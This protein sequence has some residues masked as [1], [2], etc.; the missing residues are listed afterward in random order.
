MTDIRLFDSPE[1]LAAGAALFFA[2]IAEESLRKRGRF[3]VALA[4]GSTPEQA[5]GLLAEPP[6]RDRIDWTRTEVFFGDERAV[7]PDH[8]ESNYCMASRTLLSKVPLPDANIHRIEAERTD[9]EQAARDYERIL[10][11]TLGATK[12][13]PP[14]LDLILLGIGRDGHTASIF[15]GSEELARGPELVAHML[16]TKTR[17]ARL[18]LTFPVLNA[19]RNV[20]FL[21]SGPAKAEI[22]SAVLE[23]HRGGD[24]LPPSR[25]MPEDGTLTFLLDRDAA[26]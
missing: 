13:S 5:Y 24:L 2:D 3:A 14:R 18:T 4:G 26:P 12:V 15:P 7:P 11:E 21:V 25:V 6:L 1:D 16:R 17:D 23:G 20:V 10:R 19:A 8:A 9:L 22:V